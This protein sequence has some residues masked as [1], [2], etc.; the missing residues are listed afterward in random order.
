M[1]DPTDDD[2]PLT[3]LELIRYLRS[4]PPR[5]GWPRTPT[6]EEIASE[7]GIKGPIDNW[8]VR[9]SQGVDTKQGAGL[10]L[11]DA[12]SHEDEP[13]SLAEHLA[14]LRRRPPIPGTPREDVR[15]GPG[16]FHKHEP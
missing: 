2:K 11:R 3:T 15:V 14:Y 10:C 12:V 6:L 7:Q 9:D 4:R 1:T 8:R 13:M 16:H 5:S